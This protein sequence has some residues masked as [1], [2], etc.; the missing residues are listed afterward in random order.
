MYP[1][2]Q[3]AEEALEMLGRRRAGPNRS[4]AMTLT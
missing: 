1:R 4:R 3:S 2:S